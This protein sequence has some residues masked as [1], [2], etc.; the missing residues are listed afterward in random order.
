MP[1]NKPK[2]LYAASTESHLRNFHQPYL[3]ELRKTCDVRTMAAGNADFSIPFQKSL[4]SPKNLGVVF[5]VRRI[6]RRERFDRVILNTSLAAFLIRAAMIGMRKRPFVL[7]IVHGYLFSDPPKGLRE[8]LLRLCERMTRRQTDAIAVMNREDLFATERNRFCLGK[9]HFLRGMGFV[10]A[11]ELPRPDPALRERYAGADDLLLSFVGELS[12]RKNQMFLIRAV[13]NLRAEG[14]PVKLLLV[15]EGKERAD[16]EKAVRGSGLEN[17]VFLIGSRDPVLPYFAVTDFY[18]SASRS[19]GLPFNLMEAM[20]CGLPVVASAVRGQ[21]DLLEGTEGILYPPD[22]IEAFCGAIKTLIA[23]GK[24]G[25]GAI[26]YSAL[27]QYRLSAVKE[28]NL[29]IM[30]EGERK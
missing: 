2:I 25:A 29:A 6:L 20:S 19:E 8:R 18:V 9:V 13:R 30:L 22:D 26:S 10:G 12:G 21:T 15:G 17:D 11:E 27:A 24:R 28:E 23:S 4:F 3:E 7:N 14:I 5:R 1:E 16:L